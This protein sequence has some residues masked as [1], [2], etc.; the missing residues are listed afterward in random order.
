MSRR[1]RRRCS[2]SALV[3]CKKMGRTIHTLT[4]GV[5]AP[6]TKTKVINRRILLEH[7]DDLLAVLINDSSNDDGCDSIH[8]RHC[9]LCG[10]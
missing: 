9:S 2:L 3:S 1:R 6:S 7:R 5:M 10:K 8:T 4:N